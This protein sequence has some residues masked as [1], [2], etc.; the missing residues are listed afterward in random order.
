MELI[1]IVVLAV[2]GFT[3]G[4]INE[5]NHYR[6]IEKR[7]ASYRHILLFNEKRPPLEVAGQPF[8]L[9]QGSVVACLGVI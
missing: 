8:Y 5:R 4:S 2:V 3:F 7:E 6:S 1:V 9:V